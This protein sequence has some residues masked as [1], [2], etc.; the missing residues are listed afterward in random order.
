MASVQ[1]QAHLAPAWISN[2]NTCLARFK[3]GHNFSVSTF[4]SQNECHHVSVSSC[5]RLLGLM[6][7]ASTV[8]PLGMLHKRPF[9]W[10][11]K[12][13]RIR[14]AGPAFRLLKSCFHALSIWQDSPHF[15]ERGQ[16][17]R[18]YHHQM[19]TTDASLTGWGAVFEDRP[20][21]PVWAGKF[22]SWY[23][24]SLVL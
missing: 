16:Y 9:L 13:L 22:L 17:D 10:W 5:H 2:L 23:I 21:C 20:V 1:M 19:V 6:A 24:N 7:A 15:T 14:S 18:C 8:L 11:M 3:L 4:W 12:H